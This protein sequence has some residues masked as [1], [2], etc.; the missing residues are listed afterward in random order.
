MSRKSIFVEGFDH[1]VQPIPVASRKGP[2]VITGGIYGLDPA[3]GKIPDDPAAQVKWMFWQLERVLRTAGAC[4]DDVLRMTIY[5][6]V[7]EVR[8][9]VNKHWLDA[10]PDSDSRPARH[11]LIYEGLPANMLVQCDAIAMVD[12]NG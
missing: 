12:D 2:L 7:P 3:T 5:A 11:T 6:K 10:F 9:P 1:G 4:F 8:G